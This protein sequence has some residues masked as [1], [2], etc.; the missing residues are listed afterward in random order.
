MNN[1]HMQC[2]DMRIALGD[3][4][5]NIFFFFRNVLEIQAPR[6]VTTP[7]ANRAGDG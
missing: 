7:T 4:F 2:Q 6:A 1:I 3:L 5:W